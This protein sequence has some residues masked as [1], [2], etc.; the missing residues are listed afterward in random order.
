MK[1]ISKSV[2]QS[3]PFICPLDGLPLHT[4]VQ[5]L[6]CANH[7]GFDISASGYVNLL[8]VQFK[9]SLDPGDSKAMVSARR[10]VLDTGAFEAISEAVCNRVCTHALEIWEENFLLID[11]GC[12]EG[13]YTGRFVSSLRDTFSGISPVVLG[14]DISKWAIIAASKRY[15]DVGWAVA[16]NKRLPV[17]N[18]AASMITSIFGF[19][20]WPAWAQLQNAGQLVVVVDAGPRHLIEL[21]DIIYPS[22]NVHEAPTHKAALSSGYSLISD[23]SVAF[24]QVVQSAQTLDDILEMTPHGHK[25]TSAARDAARSLSTLSLTLD[26]VI[27][28][29]RR[30]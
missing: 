18:G 24:Q 13:Y 8:P 23:T 7:H 25:I 6:N 15:Q 5:S 22:L 17:R 3:I 28:V 30:N 14:V 29:F 4:R 26:V 19:E 27:R 16:S 2:L 10:R 20:T 11:A 9:A 21:R 1:E 12:G